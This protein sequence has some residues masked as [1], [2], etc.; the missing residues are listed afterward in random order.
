MEP[1]PASVLDVWRESVARAPARP[2]IHYFDATLTV[3]EVDGLSDALACAFA[4]LGVARGDRVAVYLQNVPQ[5]VLVLL[6][7][8]KA[9]AVVVPVNPMLRERELA[10][11]LDDSGAR[12]LVTLE[13]LYREGPEV[14]ITTSEL[15]FA[16]ALPRLL[17]GVERH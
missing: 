12:V 11:L 10:R 3:A 13:S 1:R 16:D 8:F 5:F 6:A 4:D 14:V 9:G 2:L 17:A 7:A 15:D